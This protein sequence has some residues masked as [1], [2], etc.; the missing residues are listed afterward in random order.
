MR[1][2][3]EDVIKCRDVED[4]VNL[5]VHRPLQL[6]LLRP[7]VATAITPNQVTFLSLAAG[8]GSAA[9]VVHGG[10]GAL[11]AGAVLLFTSAILDGVD[12]MLARHKKA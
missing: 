1:I 7:L 12:G 3:L 6:L 5:H 9:L 8:L 2:E 10:G 11:L 4:P